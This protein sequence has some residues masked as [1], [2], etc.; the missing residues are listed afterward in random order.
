M[1]GRRPPWHRTAGKIY[2]DVVSC[3]KVKLFLL[4]NSRRYDAVAVASAVD[5]RVLSWRRRR[6]GCFSSVELAT[7][8][9][10]LSTMGGRNV[11][12]ADGSDRAAGLS[13]YGRPGHRSGK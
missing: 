4:N 7:E 9:C 12:Q 8:P 2:R 10:N 1:V 13:G 6:E 5:A 11:L 3:H